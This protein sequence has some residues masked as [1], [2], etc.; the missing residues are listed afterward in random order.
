MRIG[1]GFGILAAWAGMAFGQASVTGSLVTEA[2]EPVAGAD[3]MVLR[4]G[5]AITAKATSDSGGGFVLNGLATGDYQVCVNAKAAHLLD[6]CMWKLLPQDFTVAAG[7]KTVTGVKIVVQRGYPLQV[8][9][10]DPTGAMSK[11]NSGN[12]AKAAGSNPNLFVGVRTA[13]GLFLDAPVLST[14]SAGQNRVVYVPANEQVVLHAIG[15]NLTLGDAGGKAIDA[16]YAKI[17]VEHPG[18]SGQMTVTFQ[19]K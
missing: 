14:D 10:E 4:L 3:L 18:A 9:V 6:P 16:N 17:A 15:K 2:G 5:S 8:R 7:Q 13:K 11:T 12:S 1:I 19:V